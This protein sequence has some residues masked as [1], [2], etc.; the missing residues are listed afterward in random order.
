VQSVL[1]S[2]FPD[3]T[4]HQQRFLAAYAEL[5]N[6]TGAA[7]VAGLSR[8]RHYEWTWSGDE[9]YIAAFKAANEIAVEGLELE[10]RRRAMGGS[11]LLLIFLLKG[12]RPDMYRDNVKVDV[13]AKVEQTVRSMTDAERQRRIEELLA[14]ARPRPVAAIANGATGTGSP[15]GGP[16]AEQS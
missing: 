3:L 12:L 5:G 7:A 14:K 9:Q 1:L 13:N 2:A 10:A 16:A 4:A 15:S 11:D 8:Q 6:L